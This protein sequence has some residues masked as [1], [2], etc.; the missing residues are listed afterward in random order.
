M[1]RKI[2]ASLLLLF[3]ISASGAVTATFYIADTTTTLNRLI[4]L[5]QIEDLRQHLVISIQ[6]V[7]SD[8]YTL[9]T[10]LGRN[11]DTVVNNVT[12]L[13]AAAA[14]CVSCHHEPAIASEIQEVRGLIDR[15]ESSLSYYVTSSPN[16]PRAKKL[17]LEAATAGNRILATTEAMSLQAS[18]TLEKTTA[19]AMP[20]IR[21][22]RIILLLTLVVTLLLGASVAVHLTRSVT[23]P[24]Q[25]LVTATR[26]FASGDLTYTVD[27]ADKT[28]F[29]ELASHFNTMGSALKKNYE[30]LVREISE[31]KQTADALRV[32]EERFALAARG[33]ND[34]LWDWDIE[35]DRVYYSYR[36]KSMLGYDEEDLGDRLEDWTSLVHPDDQE[37]LKDKLTGHI[38]G[39]YPYFE[40]EFR[41]RH[42]NGSYGWVLSRGLAV[43]NSPGKVSRMAGSQTDITARKTAEAQLIHDAFHDNL[44][45]L[46][47]RSLFMDRLEHAIA[48]SRRHPAYSYA[49]LFM[50]LDRFKVIN[51]SLGHGVGDLLLVE[52]G[53]RL[54]DCIRPGDT[55]ARFGGDEFAILLE[56]I[57][58]PANAAE[59][60][61]RVLRQ[62]AKSF[63]ILRHEIH[64]SLSIG[65]A[66]ESSQYDGPEQILR[67]AD[68]AMYQAKARGR[69]CFEFFDSRMH[70]SILDRIQLEADMRLAVEKGNA[71]LLHYQPIMDLS[72]N[73]LTGFEALLRWN[74]P[75]R[76]LIYPEDFIPLA[77]ETGKILPL[78]EWVLKECTCQ[79][80]EWQQKYPADPPLRMSMNVSSKQ[81]L[82]PGFADRVS[83]V[84]QD[85][86]LPR[87]S[88]VIEITES[89]LMEHTETVV[90]MMER[91]RA[92]GV[93]IHIDDFGTGYSSLSY[94]HTFPV[95]ALKIDR[96]FIASMSGNSENQEIVKAI[97]GLAQ[98]LNLDVI[99]EG[100]E[101]RHQLSTIKDLAC[102]YY[103]GYLF[104]EPLAA[105]AMESWLDAG[106]HFAV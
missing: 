68:V 48:S 37:T 30:D 21:R 72:A 39:Q 51:D 50:D 62:F 104:S 52:V 11:L 43:R 81:F 1:K 77:E 76:G 6:T 75:R 20:R 93:H 61:D 83:S 18:R 91:L 97:I 58:G 66:L 86:G 40:A 9:H 59:V 4:T 5:H 64:T 82:Q 79:L 60:A 3:I 98:N 54:K 28:E 16:L 36:W 23:R 35:H 19:Q 63:S 41:I 46:P 2:I 92:M 99:A 94:L 38:S 29:A 100:I 65:I 88:L 67:D 101:Q 22:A 10:E 74:H 53:R 89:V 56:G 13:D 87:G 42:K 102:K 32:S 69:A 24:I 70:A 47:N 34:G 95:S 57:T 14:K 71:F 55:V 27:N 12:K 45:G 105:A 49:A 33:A 90:S 80:R 106:N 17:R 103:Q 15:Y 85:N 8:L 78:S 26:A 96:S 73:R 7:Q 84:L 31:R 44:T 25:E